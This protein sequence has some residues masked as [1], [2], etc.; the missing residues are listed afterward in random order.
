MQTLGD[1][2]NPALSQKL[3]HKD[4]EIGYRFELNQR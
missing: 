2:E 3:M 1:A 4:K